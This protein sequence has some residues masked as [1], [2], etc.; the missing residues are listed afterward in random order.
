MEWGGRTGDKNEE[1][2]SGSIQVE[3]FRRQMNIGISRLAQGVLGLANLID[4]LLLGHPNH[5]HLTGLLYRGMIA[6][7]IK[8]T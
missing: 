3:M 1:F 5:G 7:Q 8:T 2:S 6:Q 4:A